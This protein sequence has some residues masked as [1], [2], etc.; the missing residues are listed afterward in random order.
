MTP[1]C[2]VVKVMFTLAYP[3]LALGESLAGEL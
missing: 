2:A 3:D 1:E